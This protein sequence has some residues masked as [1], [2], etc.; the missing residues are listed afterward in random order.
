[1]TKEK[2]NYPSDLWTTIKDEN[3]NL[4]DINLFSDG[5]D[6]YFAIY[7]REN[8]KKMEFTNCI[9]HYKLI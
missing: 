2:Y 9:A 3:N 1:M 4:I 8:P 7:K 5:N 6:K